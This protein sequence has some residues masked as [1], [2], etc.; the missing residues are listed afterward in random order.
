VASLLGKHGLVKTIKHL[1]SAYCMSRPKMIPV[2]LEAGRINVAINPDRGKDLM[3]GT[4]PY[5]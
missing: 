3:E 2:I 1:F 4:Q 5:R